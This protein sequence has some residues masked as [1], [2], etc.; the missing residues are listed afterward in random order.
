MRTCVAYQRAW[1]TSSN[2]PA[3]SARALAEVG[4][5]DEYDVA[6][7]IRDGRITKPLVAWCI[8]T[9]ATLFPFEVQFGHAGALANSTAQ[10]AAAKNAALA[11]AGAIVPANF[12]DFVSKIR[13]TYNGLVSS[14][15]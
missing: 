7:A 1:I 14:G 8:G 6:A 9:C 10:T 4:G 3:V 12:N 2:E 13:D 15:A 5:I 11:A